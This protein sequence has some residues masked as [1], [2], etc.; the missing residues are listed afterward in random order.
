M[1]LPLSKCLICRYFEYPGSKRHF[2]LKLAKISKY[3]QESFLQSILC[4]LMSDSYSSNMPINR[5]F[6]T[7]QEHTVSSLRVSPDGVKN[8]TVRELLHHLS[9][10]SC[11]LF[12]SLHIVYPH[13]P[14]KSN[15]VW[16][17]FNPS[18]NIPPY[19]NSQQP[20]Y[21]SP[22]MTCDTRAAS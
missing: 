19:R 8:F 17:F 9:F 2:F 4:V 22:F 20:I 18:Y 5:H 21:K 16:K 10:Y 1:F 14:Q 11:I 15:L 12:L 3:P 6:I 13:N 7:F